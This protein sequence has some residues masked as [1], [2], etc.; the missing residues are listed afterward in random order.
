MHGLERL[1]E[2]LKSLLWEQ[3]KAYGISP[4]QIQILLFVSNH[5]LDLCNVSYIA[6]NF[7]ITK[8]T[9]SDAVKILVKKELVGK[10][11][12]PEDNRR[13]NLTT[14][15]KGRKMVKQLSKYAQPLTK[16]LSS[17]REDELSEVFIT[18]S[19]LIFQ[20]NQ[21]GIIQVQRTCFSCQHY[22]G[23]RSKKHFCCLLNQK[24]KSHELRLDCNEYETQ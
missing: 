20:L 6:K 13:Y 22:K 1:S 21:S 23:D 18:I 19:K 10:D 5:R 2:T 3:T 14:T 15:P 9:V 16:E 12:S 17:F 24:L 7:N 8:A 11:F 4:I